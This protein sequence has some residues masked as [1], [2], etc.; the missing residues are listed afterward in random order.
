[1]GSEETHASRSVRDNAMTAVTGLASISYLAATTLNR[2]KAAVL[3][4]L[5]KDTIKIMEPK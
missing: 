4:A 3:I 2:F 1:M 5:P